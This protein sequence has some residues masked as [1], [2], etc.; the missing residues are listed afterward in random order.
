MKVETYQQKT[1]RACMFD[2]PALHSSKPIENC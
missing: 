1:R 2:I